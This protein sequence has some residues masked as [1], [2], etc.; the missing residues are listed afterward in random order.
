MSIQM[1]YWGFKKGEEQPI[2]TPK[3]VE[4][5]LINCEL[6]GSTNNI[7]ALTQARRDMLKTDKNNLCS[8]CITKL[9]TQMLIES[10]NEANQQEEKDDKEQYDQ[11]F[12]FKYIFWIHPSSGDDFAIEM[13]S[14][15]QF[16]SQKINATRGSLKKKY[17]ADMVEAPQAI[18]LKA[19]Y[20]W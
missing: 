2:P 3:P 11:G 19:K 14:Q 6:C 12:L 13:Y 9:A 16:S 10:Q 17:N 1:K 8:D 7:E 20:N 15:A 18:D 4:P 5:T